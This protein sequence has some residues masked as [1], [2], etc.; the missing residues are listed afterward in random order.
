MSKINELI[1][2]LCPNGV[3]RI[4][5]GSIGNFESIGT[6]K[7]IVDGEKSVTLLNY[8]DVYHHKYINRN[9]PQMKVTAS[10]SKCMSCTVEKG[11]I[12][13]TPSSET[14][15]DIGHSSV[16]I[17]TIPNAVYSYHIMRFRLNKKNYTTS[18]Y[19]NYYFDSIDVKSQILKKAQGLTRYGLSKDKFASIEIPLPPLPIQ[20]EIVN[21]LDKFSSLI[22]NLDETIQLRQKQYE[23]YREKLL[24]FKDGE[25]EW[26][27]LGDCCIKC[28]SGST[29]NKSNKEF[30]DGGSI[31]WLRTQ[32]VKFNEIWEVDSYITEEAVNKTPAKW[33][34]ENC[35]IVAISGATA[36]RCAINKIPLTTNQ[37]CL[38]MQINSGVADYKYV[39]TCVQHQYDE[40]I[41][42]KQ[43]ARGDL[44]AS[45]IKGLEIPVP[46]LSRQQEIVATLDKFE[47]MISNL[48]QEREL[49]QKQ[50]EYYREKLLTFE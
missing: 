2:E 3:E 1:K 17:E 23:Y 30:Y 47:A 25:C 11:D 28:S 37:H 29:P 5:L 14:V 16:V 46:P 6:D 10:D 43:G 19:I 50:Y 12:F 34:P 9:I 20:Q 31:P 22:D 35:V 39:F 18:F 4:A 33:I 40:L 13:V 42:L 36:G 32:N 48:K 7:K 21:I 41:S 44:N 38:N 15:D 24:T 8:V 49:R 45:S 26:K 27:K